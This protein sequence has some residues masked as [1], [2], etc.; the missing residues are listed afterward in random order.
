MGPEEPDPHQ[1][2]QHRIQRDRE[3]MLSGDLGF[4]RGAGNVI[5]I[6]AAPVPVSMAMP[7]R[8]PGSGSEH[9]S[10]HKHGRKDVVMGETPAH[11]HRDRKETADGGDPHARARRDSMEGERHKMLSPVGR[12]SP[13]GSRAGRAI[14]AK[15]SEEGEVAGL[16]V[17][18]EV[19]DPVLAVLPV[20][21]LEKV[22]EEVVPLAEKEKGKERKRPRPPPSEDIRMEDPVA[23]P[24][25]PIQR[26][27]PLTNPTQEE[28]AHEWLLEHYADPSPVTEAEPPRPRPSVAEVA[29]SSPVPTRGSRTPSVPPRRISKSPV[30]KKRTPTPATMPEAALIL[31]QELEEVVDQMEPS[32]ADPDT[33]MDVD[34]DADAVDAVVAELFAET[35]EE[36]PTPRSQVDMEVDVDEALLSLLDDPDPPQPHRHASAG[37]A[38][39]SAEAKAKHQPTKPTALRLQSVSSSRPDSP[40]ASTSS[41][42]SP[43]F[44]SPNI[45]ASSVRPT[46]ERGSMPPPATV[47]A[48]K[49]SKTKGDRA[50]S[51]AAPATAARKK[52]SQ[53]ASSVSHFTHSSLPIAWSKTQRKGCHDCQCSR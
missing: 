8:R 38:S 46:P 48:A 21:A 1:R 6:P 18:A 42:A 51:V 7:V 17:K 31:E 28:D 19:K 12:R 32:K 25:K 20:V 33:E 24:D 4:G 39:A 40:M 43:S 15:K 11:V 45:R 2:E 53:F 13:P 49:G 26:P 27:L 36:E 35:L 29:P 14:A 37:S 47:D 30:S 34:V 41:A 23:T 44:V 16:G 3:R 50:G 52:V 10:D 22:K 9:G 5:G